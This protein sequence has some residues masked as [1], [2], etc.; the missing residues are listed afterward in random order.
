MLKHQ[1]S[2]SLVE[3]GE[4]I[5]GPNEIHRTIQKRR[6]RGVS[7]D[8]LN[9]YTHAHTHMHNIAVKENE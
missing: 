9:A 4:L 6:R 2:S 8:T 3:H 1:E 7:Q 5:Q